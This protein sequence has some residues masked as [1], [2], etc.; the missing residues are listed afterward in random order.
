MGIVGRYTY[1]RVVT[2]HL[3]FAK[4][5]PRGDYRNEIIARVYEKYQEALRLSNAVDFDDMLLYTHRLLQDHPDVC[6][7][8]GKRFEQILVDEF[9]DT[10]AAQYQLLRK[11]ASVNRSLFAVGDEDQSIYRWR[12]ADYRNILQFEKDFSG[13]RKILRQ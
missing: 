5:M 7:R 10:N 6:E 11:L 9:Q 12:G 3:L 2:F 1:G 8:Y 4:D 13:C